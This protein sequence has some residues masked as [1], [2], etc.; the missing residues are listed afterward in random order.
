[1]ENAT[2]A[3]EMAG[4]VL[5]GLLILGCL[6]FAYNQLA[7]VKK[8]EQTS[9]RIQQATDFNEDYLAYNRDNLYG[10]DIFSIANLIINY[11]K[12]EHDTKDYTEIT[13]SVK[14]KNQIIGSKY[15]NKTMYDANDIKNT[16]N[17][18]SNEITRVGNIK[19][20][21]KAVAYWSNYGT[22]TR[23]ENQITQEVSNPNAVRIEKLKTDIQEYNNLV[24]EQK[25]MARKTFRCSNVEY[26]QNTGRVTKME[27]TER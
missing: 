23:L 16:Y 26:D 4:S 2:K 18:L 22:S 10:S 13:I 11:N 19:Y 17:N 21:N 5:L 14:T 20:F 8:E 7:D 9:E 24:N 6:V 25:D 1:M 12:K 27:F 15:F 3:L